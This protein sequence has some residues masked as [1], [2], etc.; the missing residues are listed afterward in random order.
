MAA[1]PPAPRRRRYRSA[2]RRASTSA[3]R[4]CKHR[5][6]TGGQS[7]APARRRAPR[8][9]TRAP[10]ASAS[11]TVMPPTAPLAPVTSNRSPGCSRATSC[12]ATQ[13]EVQGEKNADPSGMDTASGSLSTAASGAS[14]YFAPGA[15]LADAQAGAAQPHPFADRKAFAGAHDAG[16][17]HA[18]DVGQRRML[19]EIAAP[20]GAV[21]MAHRGGLHFDDGAARRSDRRLDL[22]DARRLAQGM[23]PRGFHGVSIV[24]A[25]GGRHRPAWRSMRQRARQ[26]VAP[27]G[28]RRRARCS[29]RSRCRSSR[30]GGPAP[31]CGRRWPA[32]CSGCA[33]TDAGHLAACVV[34]DVAAA[35]VDELD[36]A[37]R[38]EAQA[39]AVARGL[40][41]LFAPWR[42]PPRSCAPPRS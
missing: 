40:V 24:P 19:E 30:P 27:I 18:R 8:A 33:S 28:R 20:D 15:V 6:R 3:R 39:Q 13:A 5:R 9:C 37:D 4:S 34:Q 41:D 7:L 42:R 23:D 1:P 14:M 12:S 26:H 38:R 29:R 17:L 11:C 31:P 2:H 36:H 10:R 35:E 21:D 16:G 22:V 32:R 25:A